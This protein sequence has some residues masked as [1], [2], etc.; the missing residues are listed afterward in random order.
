VSTG[1]PLVYVIVGP[2]GSKGT[3]VWAV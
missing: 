2:A 1:K 3:G